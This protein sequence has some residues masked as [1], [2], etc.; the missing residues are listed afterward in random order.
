MNSGFTVNLTTLI[1][2]LFQLLDVVKFENTD[3]L[4]ALLSLITRS[5]L[6]NSIMLT[7]RI[8]KLNVNRA[9]H[10]NP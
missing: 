1:V 6:E 2:L 5:H 10:N 4:L 3:K 9:V 8:F 7:G